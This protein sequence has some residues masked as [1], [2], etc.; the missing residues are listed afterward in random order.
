MTNRLIL[1][2]L[3]LAASPAF[4]QGPQGGGRG[5]MRADTN[6]DGAISRDEAKAQS[7]Q[8]FAMMDANK[9]GVLS[10]DEMTGSGA[11]ML[12][13]ADKDGDGKVTKAEY[14]A[15][16]AQRFARMDTN[17]DGTISADEV[18]AIADRMRGGP[19][20]GGGD[21]ADAIGPRPAPSSAPTASPR[22]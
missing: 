13:R 3:L 5:M 22:P 2:T 12:I 20:A 18:R 11:R 8:R 19:G 15:V 10:G 9:D 14:D 21:P 7:D 6:G 4:A 16:S 17:G 1:A